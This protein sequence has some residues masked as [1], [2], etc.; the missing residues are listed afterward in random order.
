M[1]PILTWF[2][3]AT[4]SFLLAKSYI[5]NLF[6]P[7]GGLPSVCRKVWLEDEENTPEDRFALNEMPDSFIAAILY[8]MLLIF[9]IFLWPIVL[10]VIIWL[11]IFPLDTE[12][13][14]EYRE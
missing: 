9:T 10:C 3:L 2:L 8:T 4:C 1:T 11:K 13:L 5:E 14:E 12:E 7:Y 6:Y